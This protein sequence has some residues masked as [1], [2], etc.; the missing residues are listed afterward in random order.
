MTK[1]KLKSLVTL[2]SVIT[3]VGFI[4]LFLSVDIGL[5]LAEGWLD[6]R[7]GLDTTLYLIGNEGF[8][9]ST[10]AVGSIL[11][12]IGLSTIIF[13]YYKILNMNE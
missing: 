8:I 3:A 10:Q 13:A 2:G 12:G 11:F 1:N 6:R 7:G 9:K 5:S 4:I